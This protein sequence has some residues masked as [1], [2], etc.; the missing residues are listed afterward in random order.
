[1]IRLS[2]RTLETIETVVDVAYYGGGTPV[3]SAEIMERNNIPPRYLESTL[4][5][6]VRKG[7]L[8]STRGPN[9]GFRLARERSRITLLQIYEVVKELEAEDDPINRF[10]QE[11][12]S[13]IGTQVL[14]PVWEEFQGLILEA[15]KGVT[16]EDLC[17]RAK[18]A[19]V[20]STIAEMREEHS[21]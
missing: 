11:Q 13:P 5:E 10:A 18:S 4:Q 2:R 20:V 7:I 12:K 14:V 17:N 6:L 3:K 8:T 1:M 21:Q 16:V 9:G 15:M 19:G